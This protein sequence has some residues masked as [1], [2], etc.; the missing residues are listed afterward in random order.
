MKLLVGGF[1][2][3]GFVVTAWAVAIWAMQN[4]ERQ[5]VIGPP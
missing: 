4:R 2:V 3:I 1:A 5:M